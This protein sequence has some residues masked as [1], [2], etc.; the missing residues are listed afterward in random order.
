MNILVSGATGFIGQHLTKRLLHDGHTVSIIVR[1]ASTSVPPE[2]VAVLTYDGTA[3]SLTSILAEKKFD[4]VMH[5]ASLFLAQHKTEDV[6]GLIDSNVLFSTQ[7]LEASVQAGIPWFIN[8]GTFWQHYQNSSYSPVNLYAATKQAFE[9]IAKYYLATSAINFVTIKLNDTF[10]PGDTRPKLFTL[11]KKISQ[12][13]ETFEMSP[14]KQIID[15]S[16]IDNVI[17]G[18]IQMMTLLQQDRERK[19]AGQSFAISSETRMTLQELAEVFEKVTQKKLN[20]IWGKKEYRPR[21]V[22]VPWDQG[23]RIPGWKP[24]V[25]LEEGIRRTVYGE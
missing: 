6:Q 25:S 9:D 4:G 5:L 17:D 15:I 14:G 2:D 16:Y 8:T 18:Y 24:S 3:A 13:Q 21:E 22:M 10:G 11:W 1:S 20:I 23:Q 19:L 7:L 12:S